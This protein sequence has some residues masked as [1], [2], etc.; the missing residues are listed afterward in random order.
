LLKDRFTINHVT[1]VAPHELDPPGLLVPI[2][3]HL[4]NR[5]KK[6][7]KTPAQL[8]SYEKVWGTPVSLVDACYGYMHMHGGNKVV[9][10]KDLHVYAMLESHPQYDSFF[11]HTVTGMDAPKHGE[12]FVWSRKTIAVGESDPGVAVLRIPWTSDGKPDLDN[13]EVLYCNAGE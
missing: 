13:L 3:S 5:K 8:K 7:K 2:D 11:Q 1:H 4:E 6:K 9:R 12:H 10:N